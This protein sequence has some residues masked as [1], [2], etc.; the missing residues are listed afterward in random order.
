MNHVGPSISPIENS[1][2]CKPSGRLSRINCYP[3]SPAVQTVF[4]SS[5]SYVHVIFP[6]HESENVVENYFK[7]CT[8]VKIYYVHCLLLH[9]II[10]WNQVG[11]VSFVLH[12]SIPAVLDCLLIPL[13][14]RASST[15]V[16]YLSVLVSTSW[17]FLVSEQFSTTFSPKA[18]IKISDFHFHFKQDAVSSSTVLLLELANS[19][20]FVF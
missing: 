6:Q 19:R 17:I 18:I 7:S 12:K 9:F 1:A 15:F 2:C 20:Y 8:E 13:S 10:G 11:E 4:H 16:P 14:T 3:L 5:K